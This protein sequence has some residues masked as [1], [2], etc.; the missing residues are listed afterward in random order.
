M[1]IQ[2]QFAGVVEPDRRY[3]I[4]INPVNLNNVSKECEEIISRH[5]ADPDFDFDDVC[6]DEYMHSNQC[7][8]G[9]KLGSQPCIQVAA[10]RA[11]QRL[12]RLLFLRHLKE[13]AQD[14]SS[15]N[16]L[17]TLEGFAQKSCIYDIK[18]L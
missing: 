18:Y 8:I 17:H 4:H 15:A 16:G 13:C 6:L 3:P 14:P 5:P 7:I 10:E 1:K 11:E 2:F 12:N 9:M